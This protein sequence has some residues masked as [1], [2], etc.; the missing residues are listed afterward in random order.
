M[1][2]TNGWTKSIKKKRQDVDELL[3]FLHSKTKQKRY[4]YWYTQDLRMLHCH[5][6]WTTLIRRIMFGNWYQ[7]AVVVVFSLFVLL[8]DRMP[9]IDCVT[10]RH[11]D[12][13][14]KTETYGIV[15]CDERNN[16]KRRIDFISYQCGW[17]ICR[18][19][20]VFLLTVA[21]SLSALPTSI[22]CVCTPL[23]D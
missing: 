11:T 9:V 3:F 15:N 10:R 20:A 5:G 22:D 18:P 13:H 4:Y 23:V 16:I 2:L 1:R 21:S 7:F 6:Q 17:P 12:R 8:L 19:S 14:F